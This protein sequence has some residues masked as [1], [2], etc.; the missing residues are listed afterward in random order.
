MEP[1]NSA[2][3]QAVTDLA[4][5][6]VKPAVKPY[7]FARFRRVRVAP[8]HTAYKQRRWYPGD[9]DL[10]ICPRCYQDCRVHHL[11][12]SSAPPLYSQDDP[13][14]GY[15]ACHDYDARVQVRIEHCGIEALEQEARRIR[16]KGLVNNASSYPF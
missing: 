2:F 10:L 6:L 11:F 8:G 5:F 13:V 14:I 4:R 3:V 1:A 9:S 12:M 15:F 7:L 16:E